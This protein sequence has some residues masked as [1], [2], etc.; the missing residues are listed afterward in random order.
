M[1]PGNI[2]WAY[3]A[4]Q[5]IWV[6]F[7]S[8]LNWNGGIMSHWRTFV[9]NCIGES[10]L[11][12]YKESRTFC[13]HF[14][15]CVSLAAWIQMKIFHFHC[16]SIEDKMQ[17]ISSVIQLW[18]TVLVS[19]RIEFV[20]F[21]VADIVLCL[22]FW[23]RMLLIAHWCF[24]LLLS[25]AYTKLKTF[26]LLI[27]PCY[28][29]GWG[30][31]RCWEGTEPGQDD[32]NW[33]KGDSICLGIMLNNIIWGNWADAAQ[34]VSRH[35]SASG[36]WPIALCI[37]FLEYSFIIMLSIIIFPSFSVLLNCL[38]LNP[39]VLSFFQVLS[40]QHCGVSEWMAVLSAR[41]NHNSCPVT[42]R[43][44]TSTLC[45]FSFLHY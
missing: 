41:L 20:F 24:K 5:W 11:C 36:W 25:N 2:C 6:A 19:A 15:I 14:T 44:T 32:P 22:G 38:Y 12:A 8:A 10:T 45:F 3:S 35:H 39:W 16:M 17:I 33:P 28:H 1:R 42:A 30:H 40:P 9:S 23:M 31:I 26:W 18:I 13:P 29:G 7:S 21:W 37:N 27:L 4:P 43:E 34:G